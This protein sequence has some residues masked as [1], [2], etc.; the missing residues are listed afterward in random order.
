MGENS[1]RTYQI[2]CFFLMIL[3]ASSIF[4]DTQP[5]TTP[6]NFEIT[7]ESSEKVILSWDASNDNRRVKH[8]TIRRDG[9]IINSTRKLTV[10]DTGLTAETTYLYELR[11]SDGVNESA[12]VKASVTTP[13]VSD[14]GGNTPVK[15][16]GKGKKNNDPVEEPPISGVPDGWQLVMSD[17]FSGSGELDISSADRNWRIETMDDGLHRAGNSG[18]DADGNIVSDWNSVRGKR[19]SAWY[20]DHNSSVVYRENGH[21]VMGGFNSGEVD[22]TRP[23]DYWDNGVFTQYGNSKLYTGWIDTWSR[24]WVGPGDLHVTDPQSPSRIFKYGYFE[25][26]VNFSQVK[27]PGF[28]ISS[29]LMPAST[30]AEGQVLVSD[31]AYDSS[32]DNGVEIDLFEYEMGG[33]GLENILQL[34]VHGGA[35]G[36]SATSFNSANLDIN[37]REGFHVIGFL[38]TADRMVWF[39]DGVP[40]KEVT[41]ISLIPDVYSYLII[42]R[43]MNSGVKRPDND[44][45]TPDDMLEEWPYIPRDPGLYAKNIWEF[46]DKINTDHALIDY[47]RVFQP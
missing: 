24:K 18:L 6:P 31:T 41:D 29:W 47:V 12:P 28:R 36:S 38:W 26:R 37:M 20:N 11:A 9:V 42:S 44:Y 3:S 39:I 16:R 5:P 22:P 19:W 23:I 25:M 15:G 40:V 35:A 4:A 2:T 43:E 17:D 21:L 34:S 46:R 7:V 27:T 13:S 10:N 45:I 33:S 30:D 14:S 1:G 32:G 8:Y